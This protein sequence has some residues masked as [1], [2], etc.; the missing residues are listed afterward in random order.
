MSLVGLLGAILAGLLFSLGQSFTLSAPSTI[1][2][3]HGSQLKGTPSQLAWSPDSKLLCLQTI[4]GDAP[5]KTHAYLITVDAR[6]FHG[7]DAPPDWAAKYWEW[8]S[9]R[10]PPGHPELVIQVETKNDGAKIPTQS[11]SDKSKNGLMENAVA[12]QNEAGS[13]TRTLTLKGE[14]IGRYVNQPL[15]PGMTFGWSPASLHAVAYAKTDGHLAIFDF[16]T[17][18]VDVDGPKACFCQRGRRMDPVSPTCR[19]QA[20][21]TTCCPPLA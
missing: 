4:E 6:T 18:P 5:G 12:A 1:V 3:W 20:D 16:D 8:K 9:S 11:L 15:V 7:L 13:V 14:T 2:E 17:V 21:E 19:R 10:T